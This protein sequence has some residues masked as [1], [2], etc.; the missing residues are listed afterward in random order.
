MYKISKEDVR[1]LRERMTVEKS[2]NAYK[3][4]Q[5]V[6]LRGEGKTNEEIGKV[7]GFNSD[8]VGKLCKT[9]LAKGLEGITA[10][11]WKGGNH[12]NLTKTETAAFLQGYEERAKKG[13]IV[14]IEE[15]GKA[16][17]KA[18]GK[19]HKSLSSI[20]YLLENHGWRKVMPKRQHPGKAS[21]EAIDASKKLKTSWIK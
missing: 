20:Y 3:R 21:G 5:A 14:T 15:I 11:G 1:E 13:E 6:A 16:Y 8:Y 7:T 2:V 9:Y 12:R 17:D 18:T 19:E 10:D 4:M